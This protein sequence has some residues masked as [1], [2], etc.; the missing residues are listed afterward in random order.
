[1]KHFFFVLIAAVFLVPAALAETRI[2]DIVDFKGTRSNQL[3]GYGLVVG[4]S[5]TGDT[6]KSAPFTQQSIQ[7]MLDR[8]GINIRG[9]Q[10]RTRNVAAVMVTADLPAFSQRGSRIDVSVAS[11]GDAKSL[12][13]GTL[14]LTAL[15][16]ADEVVYGA[17][18]GPVIIS[19]YSATG[20]AQSVT[21]GVPTSGRI[22]NGAVI[23]RDAP[24]AFGEGAPPEL[25]LRNPDFRTAVR[26]VDAINTYATSR[27]GQPI[28]NEKDFRSIRLRIPRT[29]PL[30]RVFAEIGDLSVEPD[31]I[32]RVVIDERTGT[33]VIGRDVRVSTVA[34]AHGNINVQVTETPQVSQPLPFSEGETVVVP[35]TQIQ[36][37]ESGGSVSTVK[38]ASLQELVTALNR[39]GLKP[40]GIIAILQT[41]KSA[42]ALQ[43]ELVVQ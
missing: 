2:K 3:V 11:L 12:Y 18:Q 43:A 24:G 22:A 4:L 31:Q 8:M 14:V 16:G 15:S 26:I 19:G 37:T 17:A 39:M 9:N 25:L 21:Q 23:E 40:Q 36:V 33:I 28:A 30:A 38:G 35:D 34:V 13:G 27:F 7:S 29:V 42:G 6:L 20:A 5:G 10:A 41:I 1:M 32:A